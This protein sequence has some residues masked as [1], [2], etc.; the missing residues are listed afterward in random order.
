MNKAK[1]WFLEKI[2]EIDIPLGKMTKKR[3]PRNQ[4]T[5]S[6]NERA[7]IST[8]ATDIIIVVREYDE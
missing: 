7:F 5:N 4:I 8:D 2:Y 3:R 6:R 1:S